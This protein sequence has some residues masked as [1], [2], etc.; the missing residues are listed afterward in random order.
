[1]YQYVLFRMLSQKDSRGAVGSQRRA[2]QS[3]LEVEGT[4]FLEEAV[5]EVNFVR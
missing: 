2:N 5:L 4:G 1:M 3:R